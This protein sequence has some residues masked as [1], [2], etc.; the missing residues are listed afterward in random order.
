MPRD[1]G[2]GPGLKIL[3]FSA[4]SADGCLTRLTWMRTAPRPAHIIQCHW[5]CHLH[6]HCH[7][8]RH[9]HHHYHPHHIVII[10]PLLQWYLYLSLLCDWT[11]FF[12]KLISFFFLLSMQLKHVILTIHCCWPCGIK[13]NKRYDHIS[14]LTDNSWF[15]YRYCTGWQEYAGLVWQSPGA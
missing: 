7:R 8:H 11:F 1:T 5:H 3:L 2:P 12:L 4:W 10:P 13:R 14:L 9:L 6:C 15:K